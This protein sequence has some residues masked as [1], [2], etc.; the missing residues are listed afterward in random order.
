MTSNCSIYLVFGPTWNGSD[1]NGLFRDKVD[2]ILGKVYDYQPAEPPWFV[3]FQH[4]SILMVV[5]S[6]LLSGTCYDFAEM[7]F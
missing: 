6:G 3:L 5:Y 1:L 7:Y 2:G 4:V